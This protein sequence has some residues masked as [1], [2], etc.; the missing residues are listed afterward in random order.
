[1]VGRYERRFAEMVVLP[2]FNIRLM[3]ASRAPVLWAFSASFMCNH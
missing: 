1:M 2:Q 3:S